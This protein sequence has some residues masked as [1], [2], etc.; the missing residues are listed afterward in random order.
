VLGLCPAES[1]LDVSVIVKLQLEDDLHIQE[2]CSVRAQEG[3][4]MPL[5]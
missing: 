4:T 1:S 2:G 5:Q 3:T